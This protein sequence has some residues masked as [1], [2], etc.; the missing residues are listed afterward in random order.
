MFSSVMVHPLSLL[1]DFFSFSSAQLEAQDIKFR[2]A[3]HLTYQTQNS[4]VCASGNLFMMLTVA[5]TQC[6]DSVKWSVLLR[7]WKHFWQKVSIHMLTR[8]ANGCILSTDS[9][10]SQFGF[11]YS[12]EGNK[13]P[14]RL[15]LLTLTISGKG[16]TSVPFNT[17]TICST[18][19]G[20]RSAGFQAACRL[21]HVRQQLRGS[22]QNVL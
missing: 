3:S 15:R 18:I 13:F 10:A 17:K 9:I 6:L 12:T 7:C 14:H 22:N 1:F 16:E 2:S 8:N 19:S 20:L 5:S 11:Q 21:D 4:T